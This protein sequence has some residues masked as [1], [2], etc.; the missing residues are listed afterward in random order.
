MSTL[1]RKTINNPITSERATFL[2][3]SNETNGKMKYTL[4][5]LLFLMVACNPKQI[6]EDKAKANIELASQYFTKVYNE[7]NIDLID[8]L[9]VEDYHHTNTEGR[10]FHSRDELKAA[11]KR[12][13]GLLPN[14]RLE[15]E[16][17][18]A[19]DKKVIFVIRMQSDL[20]KM[21]SQATK[22]DK[23]NFNETFVFWIKDDKII[24][25]RSIGAHLPFI[26]QVSGFEG[27]LIAD[28]TREK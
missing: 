5:L 10:V 8:E 6:V 9:F 2:Q 22:A 23:T 20:P 24:K 27:G 14:L 15:I 13:E 17:V 7:G 21:A 19:D 26:K 16:E 3:P 28:V 12:I 25:G 11:V 4:I 18:V 1:S